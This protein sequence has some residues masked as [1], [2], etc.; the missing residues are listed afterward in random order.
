MLLFSI[1]MKAKLKDDDLLRTL[2]ALPVGIIRTDAQGN[3]LYVNECWCALA[4]LSP[5]AAQDQGWLGGLHPVDRNYVAAEW[6]Q[7]VAEGV[8]FESEYRFQRPDLTSCWVLG[9]A[10]PAR[11]PDGAITGYIGTITDITARKQSELR[12]GNVIE[13]TNVG[14]WEWNVATGA[15]VINERWAEMLGFSLAQL[16]PVSYQTWAQL[17]YPD[18]L[19]A[20]E[21][22]LQRVFACLQ[23][24]YDVE[25]RLRHRAGHWVWI[26]ARGK[27]IEWSAD[28]HPLGLGGTHTEITARK[29]A[30]AALLA[31]EQK[32]RALL[33]KIGRAH[34]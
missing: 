4:G 2:A 12:L 24:H 13:G 30:E 9:Q 15:V 6:A 27:V 19:R 23:P 18:D 34:V 33:E 22:Q 10:N 25:C 8:R 20:A 1:Q 5:E 7:A 17:A 14:T 32:Y 16:S 3:C 11:T 21:G 31:S 26:H 29:Q 28:G